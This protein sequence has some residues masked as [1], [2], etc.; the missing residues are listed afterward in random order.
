MEGVPERGG[1]PGG[2][3]TRDTRCLGGTSV[4]DAGAGGGGCRSKAGRLSAGAVF[5]GTRGADVAVYP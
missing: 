4:G 1:R 5:G 2:H 3:D